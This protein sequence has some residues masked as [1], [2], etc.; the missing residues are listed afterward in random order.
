MN[1]IL[2]TRVDVRLSPNSERLLKDLNAFNA[3]KEKTTG[4]K[5]G[6][7]GDKDSSS[8]SD[9]E[10]DETER[11]K[12]V[13]SGV[14]KEKHKK[15]KRID[16]DDDDVYTPSQ[17]NVEDVQTPP[18]SGGR[19]KSNARKKVVTP[20]IKKTLK[21]LLKKKPSQEPSKPPSPPPQP[22]QIHSPIHQTPP[23]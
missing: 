9:E 15:R 17:E 8:L 12:K 18:S 23:R 1:L 5:E 7:D 4:E 3:Q 6:D 19:K 14:E 20:K 16:K 21:I 2:R 22:S 11:Y 10:I 13:M